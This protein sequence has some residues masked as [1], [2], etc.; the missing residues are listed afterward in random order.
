M[1]PKLPHFMRRRIVS[2]VNWAGVRVQGTSRLRLFVLRL[3]RG[4]PGLEQKL[5]S[6]Y[7]GCRFD[8]QLKPVNWS[9]VP[10]NLTVS[11]GRDLSGPPCGINA[12]QRSPLEANFQNYQRRP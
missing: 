3:L 6:I 11:Y 7:L 9:G 1:T 10:N 5:R 2:A 4:H 8:D 12:H